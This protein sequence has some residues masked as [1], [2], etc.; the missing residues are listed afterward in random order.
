MPYIF[1]ADK[2]N[3]LLYIINGGPCCQ[4]DDSWDLQKS[5]VPDW[6]EALDADTVQ[7][8]SN[9]L[10]LG[11]N[12]DGV[13]DTCVFMLD[14]ASG[15]ITFVQEYTQPREELGILQAPAWWISSKPWPQPTETNMWVAKAEAIKNELLKCRVLI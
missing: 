13:M 14:T 6:L 9:R 11:G 10:V 15:T 4:D 8:E 12:A 3:G 1:D 2:L 5:V 7:A